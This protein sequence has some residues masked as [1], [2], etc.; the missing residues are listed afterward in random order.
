MQRKN[1][2]RFVVEDLLRLPGKRPDLL[3]CI[4]LS[5]LRRGPDDVGVQS[6]VCNGCGPM[7]IIVRRR[8]VYSQ[9]TSPGNLVVYRRG[10][11]RTNDFQKIHERLVPSA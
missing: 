5:M 9:H 4:L 11:G 1:K 2:S 8:S 3:P 10:T 6:Q 7:L